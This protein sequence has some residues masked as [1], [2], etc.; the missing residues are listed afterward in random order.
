M[1]HSNNQLTVHT[2]GL[3]VQDPSTLMH[4]GQNDSST[5]PRGEMEN[6]AQ[7]ESVI[8]SSKKLQDDLQMIGLKIKQREDNIKSLKTKK[9]S[10]DESI[11]DMQVT[12]GKYHS[13][14]VPI[15]ENG[16]LSHVQ[17]EEETVE[18]IL[19]HEKSAAAILC[20][21]KAEPGSQ[22]SHPLLTKDVL[23][24][25]STLGKVDDDNLSRLLAEYL[26]IEAMLAVVCK[27]YDGV[28]VLETYEKEGSINRNFGL[29]GLGAFVGKPLDGRF[30]VICLESLRPYIGEFVADDPQRKLDLLKPRL[31]SG[32]LPPGFL[33][34]AVN[35]IHVD[36]VNLFCLTSN[37]HG[38]R[39]TLFYHL[40]SRLQVYRTRGDMLRAVPCVSHGAI[41]LDGG[42]IRST[43]LFSLGSR[44]EVDV[45]FPK[46]AVISNLPENYF[47][48]ENRMK[49]MRWKKERMLEDIQREQGLLD[50]AKFSFELKKQEFVK[51]LAQSAAYTTQHQI[52]AGR[53]RSTPR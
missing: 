39:E 3:S 29:H 30:L 21:L 4:V 10:L 49:E 1:F 11:L 6:G 20:Q 52:Q 17:S 48:T 14:S 16:D 31:P 40:F 24:I 25:V 8:Y 15:I 45:K 38:L 18:H 7:A 53:E 34:F 28:K 35:M 51:F 22:A 13:S 12:L 9:N 33:G 50:Q 19:R 37:G 43:G 26:G 5:I 42:M 41:S 47:E 2:A 23:G 36:S 44:E 46:R 32:E 27:T